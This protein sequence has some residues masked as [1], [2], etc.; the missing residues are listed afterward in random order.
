M[1][2]NRL[3]IRNLKSFADT[4][5]L[6][7]SSVNVLVGRNN[8]GKSTLIRGVH[9]LQSGGLIEAK[10]VR[11][12]E[13]QSA[14]E[15]ELD[16][17]NARHFP[18]SEAHVRKTGG[19][20][21]G[22]YAV[23]VN[24]NG[25]IPVPRM[26]IGDADFDAAQVANVEPNNVI[27]AYLSKRK[28]LAFNE[29]VREGR[30]LTVE[31]HLENLTAKVDAIVNPDHPAFDEYS[32]LCNELLGFRVTAWASL[33]GK[34]LGIPVG[35]HE[36]IYVE[37]MGEGVSSLLGL[38]VSLCVADGN[39]LLVE[40]PENDIHPEGLKKLL[41][42]IVE[43]SDKNQF[44]VSTHS[45]IVTKY[46][47]A[48]PN[49]KVFGV[50]LDYE[51][52]KVPTSTIQEIPPTSEARIETLKRLGYEL[53]DFDLWDGWLILE[54]ASAERVIRDY[55]IPWFAPGLSR[56]RTVAAR[57]TS[58][59]GPTF[60]DFY[61]LFRFTHLEPQY[62]ERAWVV[63][64]GDETGE[65]VVANLQREYSSWAPEHFKTFSQ[66]DFE[67]YYPK[68]F[69]GDVEQVLAQSHRNKREAKRLLLE[70][71]RQWCDAVQDEA[72]QEFERSA[73]EVIDIL[74]SIEQKL[75]SG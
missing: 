3:R 55:L 19:T 65:R 72:K 60:D 44:I 12:G 45:N 64:D 52:G 63:V 25:A 5:D 20:S 61:R 30:A 31:P 39:I 23:T 43:K 37:A 29:D 40:E 16:G 73:S 74:R 1:K 54:E 70:K 11:I 75:G 33:N 50:E 48:A 17:I 36:R 69:A 53:Y 4:G 21:S 46:L 68:R 57:G 51:A 66:P 14:V 34:K 47:G 62:K 7:L 28:V 13:A 27:Y 2:I 10:D 41:Q 32:A 35:L 9:L 38:I 67:R 8:S 56:V 71:V 18:N 59:V 42:T 15:F 6:E 26:T 58:Q 24:P 22:R 49:S